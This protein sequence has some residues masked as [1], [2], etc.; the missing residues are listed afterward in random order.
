V[1]WLGFIAKRNRA[2]EIKSKI[3]NFIE[4]LKNDTRKNNGEKINFKEL[5]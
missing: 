3:I 1:I 5:I 4:Q 2:P